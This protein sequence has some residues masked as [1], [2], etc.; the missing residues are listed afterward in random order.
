[1]VAKIVRTRGHTG[2]YDADINFNGAMEDCDLALV[3]VEEKL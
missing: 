1:M 2:A 3:L